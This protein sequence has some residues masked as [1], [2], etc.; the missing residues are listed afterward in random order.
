MVFHSS[1]ISKLPTPPC[2][3][4]C[5]GVP[6]TILISV[7]SHLPLLQDLRLKGAPS[8]AIPVILSYLPNLTTLDTEYTS[9]GNF[10]PINKPMPRLR[11]L[12]I[13]TS[14][15]DTMGPQQLWYWIRLLLPHPSLESFTLHAFSVHGS[16]SIPRHF[17]LDLAAVHKTTL[18]RL[19]L[20]GAELTL[21]DVECLCSVFPL[22]EELGCSVA[23]HD[24]VGFSPLISRGKL[25]CFLKGIDKGSYQW[26]SKLD[27]FEAAR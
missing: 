18:Q 12:T 27:H 9:A 23:S 20:D 14:T 17:L 26:R 11:N 6:A 13:R 8:T 1:R 25:I 15:L 10:R 22:M 2:L 5:A 21:K 3:Q 19:W 24:T 16:T 4:R 7:F